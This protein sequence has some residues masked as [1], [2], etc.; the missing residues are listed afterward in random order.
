MAWALIIVL[1]YSRH[2]FVWPT[3][4]QK[5]VDVIE[6]LEAAWAFFEGVPKYLVIDNFPAAV[7]GVDPLHPVS[8]AASWSTPSTGASSQTRRGCAIPGT[9]PAWSVEC[10]TCGSG[11]SRA[12]SSG[13]SR[14]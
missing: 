2:S 4:S 13:T 7:A 14:T 6:G 8:R 12:G 1:T 5:L 9:S 10:P 3:F 11:S